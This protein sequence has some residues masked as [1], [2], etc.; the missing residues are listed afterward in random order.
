M[1]YSIALFGEAEKGRFHTAYHCRSLTELSQHLG[2]P[3]H[4]E[5]GG[6]AF[7]IQ[8]LLYKY[9]VVYFRVHEE[10]FSVDDYKS[11]LNFLKQKKNFPNINA[12]C[13]PGV[14][15]KAILEETN[16]ICVLYNSFLIITERDLYDFL[17]SK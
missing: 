3:P 11:G 10:G 17:T 13:L 4:S 9:E 6:L 2:E 8:A 1:R 12:V 5:C 14:G 7:A 16:P 15:D